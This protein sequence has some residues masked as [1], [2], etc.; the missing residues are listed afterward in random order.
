[1][2]DVSA[3][4]QMVWGHLRQAP[5]PFVGSAFVLLGLGWVIARFAYR[6]RIKALESRIEIHRETIAS[7]EAELYG[8]DEPP[9]VQPERSGTDGR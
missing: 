4:V 5:Y 2:A 3:L 9:Q 8:A 6:G 7:L 1:M